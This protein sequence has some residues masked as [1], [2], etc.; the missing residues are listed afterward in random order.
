MSSVSNS[1]RLVMIVVAIAIGFLYIRPTLET[2]G[3]NQDEI[4]SYQVEII[5][6]SEVNTQLASLVAQMNSVS[7]QNQTAIVRYLPD[8]VDEVA[9]LKDLQLILALNQ[10]MNPTVDYEG[11][12]ASALPV[13]GSQTEDIVAHGFAITALMTYDQLKSFLRT[14]EQN[15]YLLEV[16]ELGIEA[17]EGGFLDVNLSL[18]VYQRSLN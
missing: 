16:A 9:V 7:T 15:N 3:A 18:R 11:M 14:I 12:S 8:E 6:I 4:Q 1:I 13:S 5:K 10:V 2:I 17:S